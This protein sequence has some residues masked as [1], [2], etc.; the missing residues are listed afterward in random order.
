[1]IRILVVDDSATARELIAEILDS[2][3]E[4]SVVGRAKDGQEAV[5][6]TAQL[7]PDVITMDIH[8]PGLD[9]FECTKQIMIECPTPIVIVSASN[10][11]HEVATGMRALRAGALTLIRKPTGPQAPDYERSVSELIETVKAMA[12]VKVVRHHRGGNSV[13]VPAAPSSSAE[14]R[15][16][17]KA[18]SK[19]ISGIIAIAASTGGPPAIQQVLAELPGNFSLP[20]LVV[21]HMAKGFTAGFTQWLDTSV[22]LRVKLACDGEA[23]QAGTVYIA[24]EE[25]HLGV[26][27]DRTLQLGSS[28]PLHGFRPSATHLFTSVAHAY[29][30][31]AL[32]IIMTGMGDDGVAG[33]AEVKQHGGSVLAQDRETSVVFGMPGAALAAGVVDQTVPL[34]QISKLM[35]HFAHRRAR[36]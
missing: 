34:D 11:V 19:D 24:A 18:R 3:P 36:R 28:P 17:P 31:A 6:M 12:D 13:V 25:L 35:Q 16:P 1:M 23:L 26:T 33:L 15:D 32:A 27:R 22:A 21:Q 4:L 20:I 14:S 10:M 30:K 29:G 7:R 8:M 5:R 9:G 2:D